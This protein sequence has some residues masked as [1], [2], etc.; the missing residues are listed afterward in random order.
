MNRIILFLYSLKG[1]F[2]PK[3]FKEDFLLK[4]ITDSLKDLEYYG[5][6]HDKENMKND[7]RACGKG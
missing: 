4:D 5:I 1:I 6:E 3:P 2:L 7:A